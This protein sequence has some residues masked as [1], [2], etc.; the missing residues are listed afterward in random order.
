M[1]LDQSSQEPRMGHTTLAWVWTYICL[2]IS[3]SLSGSIPN[4]QVENEPPSYAYRGAFWLTHWTSQFVRLLWH[5]DPRFA[6]LSS[7]PPN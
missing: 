6:L 4:L 2:E 5:E 3:P 1:H 7:R